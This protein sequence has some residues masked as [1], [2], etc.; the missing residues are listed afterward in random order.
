VF[1][2]AFRADVEKVRKLFKRIG[3]EIADNPELNADLLEPFKSQGIFSVEDG[4]LVL[5][6]KFKACSGRQFAIRKAVLAAVQRTFHDNGIVAVPRPLPLPTT[7]QA[8][9]EP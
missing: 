1:R 2:V 9:T 8:R 3:Q 6:G 4:T 5:R 7:D